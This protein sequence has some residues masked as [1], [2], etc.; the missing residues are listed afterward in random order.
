MSVENLASSKVVVVHCIERGDTPK[1]VAP[2]SPVSVI[3]Y[4]DK[5]GKPNPY[6]NDLAA[7]AAEADIVFIADN[8]TKTPDGQLAESSARV[9]A[10]IM[11][12]DEGYFVNNVVTA[13]PEP[14]LS[15]LEAV[16]S[17]GQDTTCEW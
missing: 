14:V 12:F 6:S 16:G 15:Q 13:R 2:F 7:R 8:C 5:G 1:L 3:S 10:T 4:T 9:G 11:Y 17:A